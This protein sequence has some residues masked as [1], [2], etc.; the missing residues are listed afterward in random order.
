MRAARLGAVASIGAVSFLVLHCGSKPTQIRVEIVATDC[1][2]IT[3][4]AFRTGPARALDDTRE[5]VA[6]K[7]GCDQGR[8]GSVVVTPS[9]ALDAEVELHVATG[10]GK[11]AR[12][13]KA[14]WA[15]CVTARRIVR[16]VPEETVEIVVL[17]DR[18]CEGVAC[19]NDKTCEGGVC[20]AT[21]S[22][23]NRPPEDAGPV[24]VPGGCEAKCPKPNGRCTAEGACEITCKAEERCKATCP[25]DIPCIINCNGTNSCDEVV[26]QGPSCKFSCLGTATPDNPSP[27]CGEGVVCKGTTPCELTCRG[28][29]ACARVGCTSPG[30]KLTCDGIFACSDVRPEPSSG[31]IDVSC[32]DSCNEVKCGTKTCNCSG[33]CAKQCN[34]GDCAC[35]SS[36][37]IGGGG[38]G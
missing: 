25:P 31:S 13:C 9:G 30:C 2:G 38:G 7:S 10:L 6:T 19:S 26:C 3:S 27:A 22:A 16:F 36:C 29:G 23:G 12:D 34:E 15:Q 28:A 1:T 5:P 33:S 8:I 35:R 18:R 14:P 37:N 21:T 24:V 4:T 20:V 17:I 32:T 11:E